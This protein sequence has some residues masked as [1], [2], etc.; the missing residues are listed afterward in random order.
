M[1]VNSYTVMAKFMG[2]IGKLKTHHPQL[3]HSSEDDGAPKTIRSLNYPVIL[4]SSSKMDE[5]EREYAAM[6][7]RYERV[8]LEI[9]NAAPHTHLRYLLRRK[10]AMKE[11]LRDLLRRMQNCQERNAG[12]EKLKAGGR[13]RKT[14]RVRVLRDLRDVQKMFDKCNI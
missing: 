13:P 8:K 2:A 6:Y 11:R 12:A 3:C 14:D 10:A 4:K 9:P 5:L 1:L 7:R